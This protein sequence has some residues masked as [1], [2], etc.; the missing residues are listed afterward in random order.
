MS[1]YYV[2]LTSIHDAYTKVV[3]IRLVNAANELKPQHNTGE[4][5]DIDVSADG[6]WQQVLIAGN[7]LI[8]KSYQNHASHVNTGKQKKF[9]CMMEGQSISVTSIMKDLQVEWRK[10]GC[11]F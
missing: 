4:L 7:V 2:H 8:L 10:C 1:T 3:E 11:H 6:S 5:H 9:T